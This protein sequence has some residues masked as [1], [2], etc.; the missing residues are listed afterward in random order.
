[1]KNLGSNPK[2]RG[3]EGRGGEGGVFFTCKMY[4]RKHKRGWDGLVDLFYISNINDE[5]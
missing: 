2:E 5:C 4:E 3:G 1:V